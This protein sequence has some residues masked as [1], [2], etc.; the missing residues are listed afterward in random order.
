M[1]DVVL[2]KV[3]RA[4]TKAAYRR[5][6]TILTEIHEDKEIVEQALFRLGRNLKAVQKDHLYLCGGYDSFADFCA[7]ELGT[8]K[9]HSYRLLQAFDV[10]QG[11]L[12]AGIKQEDLPPSERLVRELHGL[13]LTPDETARVWKSVLRVKKERG[14]PAMVADIQAV[15]VEELKSASAIDKQQTELIQKF[16]GVNRSLKVGLKFDCL[17][18]TFRIRLIAAL[19]DI[20]NT[21]TLLMQSLRSPVIDERF[22]A[23]DKE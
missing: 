3:E 11:L 14:T 22:D 13:K 5:Y 17:S 23:E 18:P 6:K 4:P 8:S 10:M 15:A 21:A 16:E 19:A 9:Q 1:N 20:A 2:A 12:E 7:G